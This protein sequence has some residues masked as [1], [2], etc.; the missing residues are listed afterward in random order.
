[1]TG[2]EKIVGE[3]KGES[4]A[5]IDK[6]LRDAQV[7]V[8]KIRAEA[9]KEA[10]DACAKIQREGTIRVAAEKSRAESTAELKRRQNILAEKQ[11]L[12]SEM[13]EEARKAILAL[14]SEKYFEG[15]LSILKKSVLNEKGTIFFNRT[16]LDRL[17]ASFR[18]SINEVSGGNLTIST[19]TKPID[20][21]FILSYE[22]IEE[23]CSVSALFETKKEILQ[24][25][26]QKILFS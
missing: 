8:D 26:I 14:P 1:M 19:E 9:D 10:D 17:P 4:D 18:G 12:I 22:G 23:N 6:I 13:E 20:G 16:D 24:D 25:K 7:E 3:I 15:I 2:L 11:K 21:G 5:V